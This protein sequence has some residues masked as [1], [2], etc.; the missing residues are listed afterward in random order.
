MRYTSLQP[1]LPR[2]SFMHCFY[3]FFCCL[4]AFKGFCQLCSFIPFRRADVVMKL[5]AGRETERGIVPFRTVLSLLHTRKSAIP[6]VCPNPQTGSRLHALSSSTFPLKSHQ[7]A[8]VEDE[9]KG[10]AVTIQGRSHSTGV[11]LSLIV[12][13]P[14]CA[15]ARV[16]FARP[17]RVTISRY[18][19]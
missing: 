9:E 10:G 1:K 13:G 19:L 4:L 15:S 11:L 17:Y 3:T 12:F 7:R 5:Q 8:L 2:V 18:K 16:S 6:L 14:F